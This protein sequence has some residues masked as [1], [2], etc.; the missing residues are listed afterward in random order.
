MN[1]NEIF[2]ENVRKAKSII[3]LISLALVSVVGP[4]ISMYVSTKMKLDDR[5]VIEYDHAKED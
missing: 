5:P 4:C 2:D 3:E 1:N